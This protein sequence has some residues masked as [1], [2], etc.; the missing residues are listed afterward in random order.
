[1]ISPLGGGGP[2]FESRLWPF[3]RLA[4][5]VLENNLRTSN[6]LRLPSKYCSSTITARR[7]D[8]GFLTW[9][10]EATIIASSYLGYSILYFPSKERFDSALNSCYQLVKPRHIEWVLDCFMVVFGFDAVWMGLV[11]RRRVLIGRYEKGIRE[12]NKRFRANV[13]IDISSIDVD[14]RC[15]CRSWGQR[16]GWR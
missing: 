3:A 11:D 1:M 12:W 5:N 15:R 13:S 4:A 14:L 10:T 16:L 8:W 7:M 2:G 6:D 9:A